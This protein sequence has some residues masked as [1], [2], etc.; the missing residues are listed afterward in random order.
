MA[1]LAQQRLARAAAAVGGDPVIAA[2]ETDLCDI[3]DD[4]LTHRLMAS[5]RV[6]RDHLMR[7]LREAR[8]KLTRRPR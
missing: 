5:D 8:S 4:P 6:E 1:N 7:L 3:I 2:G